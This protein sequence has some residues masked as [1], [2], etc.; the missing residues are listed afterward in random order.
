MLHRR[1]ARFNAEESYHW[2]VAKQLEFVRSSFLFSEIMIP[3]GVP[4]LDK[5]LSN[6]SPCTLS[7]P[8]RHATTS[9][10]WRSIILSGLDTLVEQTRD[11]GKAK[12]RLRKPASLMS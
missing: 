2:E 4:V 3:R 11:L 12:V 7:F 6:L 8:S 10:A 1:T 5:A 9:D